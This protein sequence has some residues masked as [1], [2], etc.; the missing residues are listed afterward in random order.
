M[1]PQHLRRAFSRARFEHLDSLVR[2]GRFHGVPVEERF[3]TSGTPA[4]KDTEN[5]LVNC[6]LYLP[7]MAPYLAPYLKIKK[8]LST[9][10]KHS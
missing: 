4:I 3:C 2:H 10:E 6:K 8:Y 1:L 5:S 7:E 9:Q